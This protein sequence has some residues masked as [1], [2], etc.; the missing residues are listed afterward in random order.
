MAERE[1]NRLTSGLREL[2]ARHVLDEKWLV[3]PSRR[4]GFQWLDTVARSGQPVLNARVK[5][6]PS[7]ALELAAPE[8]NR[9]GLTYL[10]GIASEVLVDRVLSRLRDSGGEYLSKLDPGPGLIGTLRSTLADL[11]LAGL[12]ARDLEGDAFEVRAKGRD[13][14]FLLGEYEN[15]LEGFGLV[16]YAGALRLA[17]ER[18]HGT[19]PPLADGTLVLLSSDMLTDLRGLERELWE[20]V[21]ERHRRLLEVDQP[22]EP[23]K[24][25]PS[26]ASLLAWIP[27]PAS[28]PRPAGDGT[29]RMFRAV[30]EVNEVREVLRRCV[31]EGIPFD[32]VEIIHTDSSTYPPLVY[33]LARRLTQ[34]DGD[35]PVTF[36]G[37]TPARYSRPARALL[38]WLYWIREGYP[39]SVLVRMVQDGLLRLDGAEG[40]GFARLGAMLRSLPIGEGWER[41]LPAME[42]EIDAL[43]VRI[44]MDG[45]NGESGAP[46]ADR[47]EQLERRVKGL[48]ALHGLTRDLLDLPSARDG[49]YILQAAA[50]FL[51][52]HARGTGR[53][54]EYSLRALLREI[55]EFAGCLRDSEPAGLKPREWL[56]GLPDSVRVEGQG[57]RPGCLYVTPIPRGGHSGRKHTFIIGLDDTRFPGAGLQDPLL[58]DK[59]RGHL[60]GDLPIASGR[61]ARR[62]DELA[63]L[64]AGLRGPV[65]MSYCCRGLSDDREMF[66]SPA[67]LSAYRIIAGDREGVQDDLLAW[68]PDPVSFAPDDPNKCIDTSEWWLWRLCG[69]GGVADPEEA[70][71]RSFPHLGRGLIARR[72]RKSKRFT[73]YDGFVPEAGEDMDPTRPDGPVLSASRLETLGKCP[74]EYF[75]RYILGIEPPEEYAVDTSTWLDSGERGNLLH[76]VFREFMCR[77]RGTEK[78]PEMDRDLAMLE[79]ILGEEIAAWK[80]RKPPPNREIYEREVRELEHTS[81]IFLQEE[82]AYCRS[83]QPL[84]FEVAIG[85]EPEGGGNAI[86][87]PDPLE[88]ELPGGGVIRARGYIDRV[89]RVPGS[90]GERFAVCDYKTGS[91]WGFDEADPFRQG[92][93]IQNA[94]YMALVRSRLEECHPGGEVEGFSYFFPNTRE[95]GERIGWDSSILEEGMTVLEKLCRMLRTGCFPFTD[96][97]E[98][99][100]YSDYA[101]AFGDAEAAAEAVKAKLGNPDNAALSPFRDLR[102]YGG[103]DE[104]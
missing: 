70:V 83:S 91:C 64:L 49:L 23:A 97:P 71:S 75:F 55:E 43:G 24:R 41:Y 15:E 47:R 58:L 76:A 81:R 48:K 94:L 60:S 20:A 92:R 88:V 29:V 10:R 102:G 45:R 46:W 40:M 31:D 101:P 53:M 8:M 87:C 95:H 61:M 62:L 100:T 4:V 65:T 3:A 5:S 30:G 44:D 78:L 35:P 74:M 36:S 77:L 79:E 9:R 67:Q 82:E 93:L 59:E 90:E 103:E 56:A 32:E 12:A 14:A 37:G 42:A 50:L 22:C 57:P 27:E 38:G 18:L 26:D 104:R 7:M 34:E 66:P 16:D 21:P 19:P 73:T 72:E 1:L 28:A 63:K 86:D 13:I 2:C 69:S 33:E 85:L 98:D 6:L 68:L 11:R 84:Y 39:Q 80:A 17:T 89:D 52:R 54:D 96:N 25:S 99:I 51:R